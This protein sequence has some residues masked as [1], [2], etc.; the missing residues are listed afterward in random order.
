MTADIAPFL[1]N[2]LT[3]ADVEATVKRVAAT[4]AAPSIEG[5]PAASPDSEHMLRLAH[6]MKRSREDDPRPME[7]VRHNVFYRHWTE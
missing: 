2:S 3:S 6:G 5:L 4:A 1:H 7:K